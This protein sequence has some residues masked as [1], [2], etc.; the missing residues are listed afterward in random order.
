MLSWKA[1]PQ[2]S[3]VVILKV[4]FI[5]LLALCYIISYLYITFPYIRQSQAKLP[6]PGRPKHHTTSPGNVYP[7]ICHRATN[8]NYRMSVFSF[9]LFSALVTCGAFLEG[10]PPKPSNVVIKVFFSSACLALLYSQLLIHS[11]LGKAKQNHLSQAGPRTTMSPGNVYIYIAIYLYYY[12]QRKAGAAGS[13]EKPEESKNAK[14]YLP[15]PCRACRTSS[16]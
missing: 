16:S 15:L 13:T 11:I 3:N 12:D 14:T 9:T 1:P 10:L 4:F 7:S 8:K 2:A 6:Q 5:D